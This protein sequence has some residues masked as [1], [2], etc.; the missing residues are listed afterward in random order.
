MPA[1]ENASEQLHQTGPPSRSVFATS[2][3]DSSSHTRP[4]V[5]PQ[6]K[7]TQAIAPGPGAEAQHF[8]HRANNTVAEPG[9]PRTTMSA[10]AM[11]SKQAAGAGAGA[12]GGGP[13]SAV[14]KHEILDGEF[15]G[16]SHSPPQ[17]TPS[18]YE[19]THHKVRAPASVW[20]LD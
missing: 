8:R 11:P 3:R 10:V 12:A 15:L 20:V 9:R 13:G 16:L 14:V 6:T 7:S 2:L 5:T 17:F 1:S 18:S 19:M 4:L